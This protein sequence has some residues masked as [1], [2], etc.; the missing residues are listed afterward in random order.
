MTRQNVPASTEPDYPM[1]RLAEICIEAHD[2]IEQAG[3]PEMK[4]TIEALLIRVGF[5]LVEHIA[6]LRGTA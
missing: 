3:T 4:A 2:L 6:A 5:G 1:E